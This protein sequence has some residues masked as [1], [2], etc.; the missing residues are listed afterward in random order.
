MESQI[1][2]RTFLQAASC[3]TAASFCDYPNLE[4]QNGELLRDIS[5]IDLHQHTN[6]SG[7]S[8]LQLRTHQ[9]AMGIHRSVLLPAGKYYGLAATC[10]GNETVYRM[11]QL[12][13]DDFVFFANEVPDLPMAR[14]T[15]EKYLKLGA[16][17]IGEQKFE[18]E[19][20]SRPLEMVAELAADYQVPVLIH[21][22]HN[23]YNTSLDR[24][25]KVLEKFP[26]TNFIGHAQTWWGNID[27]KHDQKVM[28][29]TG[30]VTPGGITDRLLSDYPNM[31]GD[32]SAGSGLNSLKRDEDHTRGFLARHQDKLLYGSDCNDGLGRGP[33][34]QGSR[35]I[36]TVAELSLNQQ[37][38]SKIFYQNASRLLK[39]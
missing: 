24:F 10:G 26:N 29:P 3:A 1:S 31:F 35:T 20:D 15:I 21:F 38:R 14:E 37:I 25:H 30:R 7:R 9:K 22:Q 34:C 11:A 8:D 23:A 5:I 39:I 17:G 12:Y 4:A 33:G 27:R 16:V 2:R 28:Y 13:P 36:K 32:L 19:C 18:L 6:Y